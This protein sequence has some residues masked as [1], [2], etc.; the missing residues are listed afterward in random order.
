MRQLPFSAVV[1]HEDAKM[2]LLLNAVDP[3]IGGVLLRGDKG[4]AKST[5]ARGLAALLPGDAPF[6]E[7]PIGAT[8]DRLVGTLDIATALTGGGTRFAP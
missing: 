3:R 8:E 5:L 6:V 7:L 4:S 1:G 2:A